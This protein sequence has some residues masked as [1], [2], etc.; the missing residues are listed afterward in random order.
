[1]TVSL[2]GAWRASRKN[3]NQGTS[4]NG[5]GRTNRFRIPRASRDKRGFPEVLREPVE[6]VRRVG[7]QPITFLVERPLSGF[8]HACT[9][10]DICGVLEFV[11]PGDLQRLRLVLLRQPTRKQRILSPVWGRALYFAQVEHRWGAAITLE[12]QR[13]REVIRWSR[14]VSLA[15]LDELERLRADGHKVTLDRR[16]WLVET[17]PA[18]IR[19]TQLFR[20]LLHE[21]GHHVDYVEA[22]LRPSDWLK[23]RALGRRLRRVY[24]ARPRREHEEFAHRYAETIGARIVPRFP[25]RFD[26]MGMRMSALDPAWFRPST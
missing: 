3:R 6:V 8:F 26:F 10:D 1:M 17:S 7:S 4:L 15:G 20:T 12:S 5:S 22:V 9:I 13:P 19:T 24:D 25:S 14:K 23:D 18:S 11:P 21:L 16:H 2:G